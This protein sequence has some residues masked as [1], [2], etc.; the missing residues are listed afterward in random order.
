MFWRHSLIVVSQSVD[1]NALNSLRRERVYKSRPLMIHQ[2][3]LSFCNGIL[4]CPPGTEIDPCWGIR[5]RSLL[6][7]RFGT[8]CVQGRGVLVSMYAGSSDSGQ[9]AESAHCNYYMGGL[10]AVPDMSLLRLSRKRGT[11]PRSSRSTSTT[12]KIQWSRERKHP[13]STSLSEQKSLKQNKQTTLFQGQQSLRKDISNTNK[14]V[15]V[16]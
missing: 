7:K 14:Q 11:G 10:D 8:P 1:G 15:A 6:L 9:H 12:P 3:D 4:N 13:S 2:E 5:G 16:L